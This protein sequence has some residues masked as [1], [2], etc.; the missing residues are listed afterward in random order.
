MIKYIKDVDT[1]EIYPINS[2]S[3]QEAINNAPAHVV[4]DFP[5]IHVNF[6]GENGANEMIL[7]LTAQLREEK[8]SKTVI[9]K[10]P[11][12]KILCAVA[13]IAVIVVGGVFGVRV[14]SNV[15]LQP[16]TIQYSD[17]SAVETAEEVP[18]ASENEEQEQEQKTAIDEVYDLIRKR[19]P[20]FLS[21]AITFVSVR[22]AIKFMLRVVK[23]D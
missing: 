14:V 4:D 15:Q 1:G 23:N 21:V 3:E 18:T 10:F 12:A 17:N 8:A 6:D 11:I 5:E 7:D 9:H 19:L 13:L 22:L 20:T 16:I 2:N